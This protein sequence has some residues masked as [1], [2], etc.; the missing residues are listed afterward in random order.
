MDWLVVEKELL[1]IANEEDA[2]VN[3]LA[4]DSS[5]TTLVENEL[6]SKL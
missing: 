2:V 5:S 3:I 4:V 1:T 6:L